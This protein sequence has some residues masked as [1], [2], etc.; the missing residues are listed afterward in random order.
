MNTLDVHDLSALEG[1]LDAVPLGDWVEVTTN[2][3]TFALQRCSGGWHLPEDVVIASGDVC[4][5][6]PTRVVVLGE[7]ER[8]WIQRQIKDAPPLTPEQVRTIARLLTPN[9]D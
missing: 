1:A 3:E 5:G 8:A 7:A 2:G 6:C 9:E 4:D